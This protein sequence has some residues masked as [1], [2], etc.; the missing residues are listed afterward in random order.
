M[1]SYYIWLLWWPLNKAVSNLNLINRLWEKYKK[2]QKFIE[3]PS[4]IID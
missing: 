4:E 2:F 1:F 3:K